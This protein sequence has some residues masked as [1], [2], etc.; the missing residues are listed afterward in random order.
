MQGGRAGTVSTAQ[1]RLVV[2]GRSG[3]NGCRIPSPCDGEAPVPPG[4]RTDPS[5]APQFLEDEFA[6]IWEQ[7]M[8]R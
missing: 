3:L 8:L 2:L 5:E 4:R 1:S 7:G 6:G